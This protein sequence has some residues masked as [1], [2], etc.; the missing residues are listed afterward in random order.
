MKLDS[1]LQSFIKINLKLIKDLNVR[2]TTVKLSEENTG[3]NFHN[4]RLD[5]GFLDVM[6]KT[7]A[8]KI[9]IDQLDFM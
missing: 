2:T 3:I 7:Q 4:L 9:K 5:N 1:F 8:T 6:L